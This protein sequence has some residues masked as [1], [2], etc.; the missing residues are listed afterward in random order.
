MLKSQIVMNNCYRIIKYIIATALF[1]VIINKDARAQMQVTAS[2]S[3]LT[4]EDLVRN[5]LLGGGVTVTNVSYTGHQN[6]LGSFSGES[7]IGINNG[8]VLSSGLVTAVPGLP[9]AFAGHDLGTA[10]DADLSSL[11]DSLESK[12]AAVLEFDFIPSANTVR[13]RFTFGSEEYPGFIKSSFQDVFAFFITGENPAEGIYDR[14]NL[15]IIPE[16][17]L[18]ITIKNVNHE[19]NSRFYVENIFEN[20]TIVYNGYTTVFTID[21]NV[22]AGSS[23]HFKIAI[24]DIADSNYDSGVFIEGGSFTSLDPLC[25]SILPLGGSF[26]KN[27]TNGTIEYMLGNCSPSINLGC[28]VQTPHYFNQVV[29]AS[30]STYTDGLVEEADGVLQSSVSNPYEGGFSGKWRPLAAYGYNTVHLMSEALNSHAGT[31]QMRAFDWQASDPSAG[32]HWLA[33]TQ[34]VNYSPDGNVLEEIN[35][36]GISNTVKFGYSNAVPYL[37]AQNAGYKEVFFESF[38]NLYGSHLEDFTPFSSSAN[39]E[40]RQKNPSAGE[41]PHSGNYFLR[42]LDGSF[43]TKVLRHSNGLLAKVWVHSKTAVTT[44]ELLQSLFLD[45]LSPNGVGLQRYSLSV[46][47]RSGEWTLCEVVLTKE[48]MPVGLGENFIAA[49][50]TTN[51]VEIWVDDFRLQPQDALMTTYVYEP[52][53]LK[54][55]ASFDDRHFGLYYQYNA[56]GKLVRKLIETERGIQTI[57]ETQYNQPGT[58]Y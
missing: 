9:D 37:S 47:G 21:A 7:S 3:T 28:L 31:F 6:A 11:V 29:S 13:F 56:E 50:S 19:V 41:Y 22:V 40:R 43:Q 24:S 33:P 5:V 52:G 2:S 12:D 38:E 58:T 51:N 20:N 57:Q 8:I 49:L 30:S 1:F 36:L 39:M 34:S 32:T 55:L 18:P 48:Q 53:N 26:V 46:V 44:Q 16:T 27:H 14:E 35:L 17:T 54:L 45:V 10:G 42:L 15:A 23:Y 4:P 25:Q